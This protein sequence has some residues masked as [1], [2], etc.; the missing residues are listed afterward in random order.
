VTED[1]LEKDRDDRLIEGERA[2]ISSD[3]DGDG[4]GEAERVGEQLTDGIFT[5][6]D[7]D[8]DSGVDSG[9]AFNMMNADR[10]RDTGRSKGGRLN[11]EHILRSRCSK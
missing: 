1:P 2:G 8:M 3:G 10:R 5:G 11:Q 4:E 7:S 9:M 6:I